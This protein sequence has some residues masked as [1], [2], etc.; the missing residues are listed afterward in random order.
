[1]RHDDAEIVP[2][3]RKL[4]ALAQGE[5]M[6]V[7]GRPEGRTPECAARRSGRNAAPVG[8]PPVRRQYAV[9][10]RTLPTPA[11]L[12]RWARAALAGEAAI[13]L[14]FVGTREGERLNAR[15]RGGD[16]AT[17]VLTFVYDDASPLGGDLV[18]CA[19]VLRREG[20]P[21]GRNSPTTAPTSSSTACCTCKGYDH[22]NARA[23]RVMEAR[24]TAILAG[25]GIPDPYA[26]PYAGRP[27]PRRARRTAGSRAA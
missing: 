11:S 24:E 10:A 26:C 8:A 3:F 17:N 20:P 5:F 2:L 4:V 13:T 22:G 25:L 14:R 27:A 9:S 16:H 7:S 23:A 18:L 1:M 21:A 6:S 12:R 15:F 19:P